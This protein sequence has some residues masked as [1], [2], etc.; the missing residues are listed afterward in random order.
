MFGF[1][2]NSYLETGYNGTYVKDR[3]V[4][5]N[6]TV[7]ISANATNFVGNVTATSISG[8][9]TGNVVAGTVN[10]TTINATSTIVVGSNLSI[11]TSVI[12]VGNSTANVYVNSTAHV[13]NVVATTI[14]GN[15][16]GNVVATTISG[17]LTGNVTATT[18]SGNLT[19]ITANVT[20]KLQIGAPG[21]FDFGSNA[22]I[23]VDANGNT[24][25]QAVLQNANTGNNA[26]ADLVVTNDT[27]NDSFNYIDLGINGSNYNQAG[28]N[29]T[30]ASDAYLYAS[31][32]NL[33]IGTASAKDIIFHAGG[34]TASDRKM[35]INT[36]AVSIGNSTSNVS[37]NSIAFV[38]NVVATAISGNLTGNVVATTISGNLTGNVV[39]T[40]ISGNLTGNVVATTISGNLTG[41]VSATT[42]S[43]S[44]NIAVGANVLITTANLAIGNSTA[45]VYVN[46]TAFVGNVVATSVSGNLSG[47]VTATVISSGNVTVTG[48][49]NA[50]STLAAGNTTITGFTNASGNGQFSGNVGIGII[51]NST[52]A[53]YTAKTWASDSVLYGHVTTMTDSNTAMTAARS[54]FSDLAQVYN[55]NQNKSSD[56]LTSY[57]TYYIAQDGDAYNGSPVTGGD[58]RTYGLFG[59]QFRAFN[60][61]NGVNANTVDLARGA[62]GYSYQYGSGVITT[63]YGL[64]GGVAIGNSSVTGNVTTAFGMYSELVSNTA[65]TIASGYLYYGNHLGSTTT[66]KWGI[67]LTGETKSYFSGNVGIGN[68]APTHKLSVNGTTY[69]GANLTLI[70]T[71]AIVANSTAGTNGQVLTSNGSV[72]YW[73]TPVAAVNVAAQYAWTNTHTYAAN[74]TVGSSTNNS[75]FL[76]S[77]FGMSNPNTFTMGAITTTTG[78]NTVLAGPYVI[79]TGN[80][81]TIA[82]GSRV[83]IV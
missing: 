65:A 1:T 68:T 28:F 32:G 21:S 51:P 43:A 54:K 63:A 24:Y 66:N 41:N 80:T 44:A 40:T 12:S 5:G 45:N 33:A 59:G 25:V 16:T 8:N 60:Y 27:G 76:T 2:G 4:V 50:T 11:N 36:T 69:L 79:A 73:S 37:I 38:G 7:S 57:N 72:T 81:L 18:I 17:N 49:V 52:V 9:L 29:I 67:Y 56:G 58:A 70:S 64:V 39:A 23:E 83:V 6:S 78:I 19:A 20:N 42:I 22:V 74:V 35:T 30:G 53:L 77:Y 26:S 46:S 47:N 55:L 3:L 62:T 82:T 10:A 48:F 13:G 14:T 71:A 61:A 75:A 31:H 34:T 15:L